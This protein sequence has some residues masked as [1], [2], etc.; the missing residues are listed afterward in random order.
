[1]VVN[2]VILSLS[3]SL[4]K[5][6]PSPLQKE[7]PRNCEA[8]S[9]IIREEIKDLHLRGECHTD[10]HLVGAPRVHLLSSDLMETDHLYLSLLSFSQSHTLQNKRKKQRRSVRKL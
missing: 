8:N 6:F 2:V 9:N 1:M 5:F 4:S 7:G 10:K 3:L